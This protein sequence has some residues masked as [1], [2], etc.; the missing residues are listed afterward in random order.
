[1]ESTPSNAI[2]EAIR[3]VRE[4][5]RET[6]R[7]QGDQITKLGQDLELLRNQ[8][9]EAEESARHLL[10]PLE[11][12]LETQESFPAEPEADAP[13]ASEAAE[14]GEKEEKVRRDAQRFSSLLVSEVELYNKEKVAEGRKNKDLYQ[15]LKND[16]NC[17]R[18]TYEKRFGN[19]VSKQV[20]YFH[21]EL[22]RA[23][24]GNDPLLLGSDY[25]GPSV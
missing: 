14:A 4:L 16:I 21:E 9:R 22:V 18:Q 11:K 5:I 17:S 3:Q 15:Y 13:Q 12:A 25:P 7:L 2:F 19:T 8:H 24:A 20:D 10:E 23:L 6:L 1:M